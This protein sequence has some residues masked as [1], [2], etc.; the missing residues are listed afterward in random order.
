M[1]IV[2]VTVV[3]L[4]AAVG[5][6]CRSAKDYVSRGDAL[7]SSNKNT[8]AILAYRKAIQKDPRSALAYYKLG[9]V[10]RA[11]GDNNGALSSFLQAA[12]L[13]PELESAQIELGD[14]Y[15]GAYLNERFKSE[16]VHQRIADIADRLLARNPKSHAGLRYRGYLAISD[17]K[18]EVAVSYFQR[19]NEIRP[20]QPDV[21]LG[22]IQALW[23]AGRNDEARNTAR[24]LIEKNK[25]FGPVYDVL[26]AHEM[27]SGHAGE[28]EALLK[29]KIANNPGNQAFLVQLGEHYWHTRKRDEARKLLDEVLTSQAPEEIYRD[30][31]DFYKRMGELDRALAVLD[32]GL[33][34]HPQQKLA[35]QK[36]Q[37]EIRAL[38]GKP[39]EAIEILEG[40]IRDSPAATDA[41]KTRAVLLLGSKDKRRQELALEELK[42]LA[43]NSPDEMDLTVQL[44]RAYALNGHSDKAAQQFELVVKKQATNI[45]ALLALAELAS[46]AKQF[47]RCLGFSERVLAVDPRLSQA[48]LLHAT[49]LVGLGQLDRARH[50]YVALTHDEPQFTEAKLQLAQLNVVQRRFLEAEKQ[51]REIYR[52]QQGDFRAL[53]GLVELYAS[54]GRMEAALA[55]LTAELMRYPQSI[56]V[57][58][59]LAETAARANRPELALQQYE[60][61]LQRQVGDPDVYTEMGK[62]YQAAHN[63][64]RSMAMLEKARELAPT[65]WRTA[66]RLATVQQEAGLSQQ[67]ES[68]YEHAVQLGADDAELFNNLAY[69]EAEIGRDLDAA[70][71]HAQQALQKSP[72]NPSYA[73]TAGFVYL[74]KKQT[75]AAL[76]VF[77]TLTE[78]FPKEAIFRYHFALALRQ[79]GDVQA[80]GRELRAALQAD[81]SLA[82]DPSAQGILREYGLKNNQAP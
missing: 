12:A 47:Q 39:D 69:L 28:A 13:D 66:A 76:Q 75:A 48:R 59:M 5:V 34:T 26:Y 72:A 42:V 80:A 16:A 18:P 70:G 49:A 7:A 31:S 67:A 25:T 40:V 35:F 32:Q 11:T 58:R 77:K 61:V 65:D 45:P 6:A 22:L 9:L 19:A 79:S 53:K 57:R 20:A 43:A 55:L 15:L 30:V 24:D 2:V 41:K 78:R 68:N 14:L 74:K 8:D 46:N 38:Q 82:R 29:V 44:G 52:P 73:D 21:S 81:G 50:E 36:R 27:S 4:I 56:Y 23:M 33:K 54:Q 17:N 62:L 3:V 1:R 60:Q 71:A 63:L 64:P 10:L 51:F 37:A